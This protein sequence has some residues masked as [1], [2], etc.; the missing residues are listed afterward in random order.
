M[1]SS[2]RPVASNLASQSQVSTVLTIGFQLIQERLVKMMSAIQAGLL[3]VCRISK[4]VDEGKVTIG[5]ISLVKAY[6]TDKG[7]DVVRWGR[8]ILG[9]NG[10]LQEYQLIGALSDMEATHTYEG[11]YEVNTLVA[12]RELT[13]ISA[14]RSN[15]TTKEK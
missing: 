14:F 2:M 8:E 13:G 5:Q 7:R 10:I 4:M 11:T 6:L 3:L 15:P 12:G 9:G 1:Q